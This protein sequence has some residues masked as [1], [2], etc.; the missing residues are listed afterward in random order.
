MTHEHPAHPEIHSLSPRE[1]RNGLSGRGLCRLARL[2]ARV[3]TRRD[4]ET[5]YRLAEDL[6]PPQRASLWL[7]MMRYH[8]R[9]LHLLNPL[10]E[11]A[12]LAPLEA[13]DL[14][15]TPSE[16]RAA[17]CEGGWFRILGGAR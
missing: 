9:N 3:A 6:P 15:G 17:V 12:G 10:F 16:Y 8:A 11:R 14:P 2:I 7:V 1:P 5:L 13:G 4:G